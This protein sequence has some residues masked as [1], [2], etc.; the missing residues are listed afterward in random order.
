MRSPT[1][2]HQSRVYSPENFWS[3]VEK[4]FCNNIGTNPNCQRVPPM[5]GDWGEIPHRGD[6]CS[7]RDRVARS[8]ACSEIAERPRRAATRNKVADICLFDN[9]AMAASQAR[10]GGAAPKPYKLL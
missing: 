3:S 9:G 6:Y 2:L 1:S 7:N 10:R 5:S 4:D 8:G